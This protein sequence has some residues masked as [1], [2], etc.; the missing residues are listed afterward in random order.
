VTSGL[1][2]QTRPGSGT[3]DVIVIGAGH[4]GLAI[5]HFLTARSIEHVVLE[6]GE[7]ANSWRRERWDSLRLLTPNWQSRLPGFRYSGDDPDG[8]MTVKEVVDF[9]AK[10]AL[11]AD[12]PVETGTTVTAVTSLDEGFSVSTDRGDWRCRAVVVA[13]GACNLPVIP[14][15]SEALP[16]DIVQLTP[17]H[18][19]NPQQI[20]PGGV[21]VV[22]AS[23]TGLQLA[24][25]MQRAGHEVVLAVGEHVRMP[26]SYRGRDIQWWMH[27]AG[28]LDQRYDE[29]DDIGRA[30]RV[31]SPQLIGSREQTFMDLNLIATRGARIAGRLAGIRGGK[32]LFSGSL[33][34]VCALA[35]LKM[36]RLLAA[37]DQWAA[38]SGYGGEVGPAETFPATRVPPT[39]C[40]SLDLKGGAIRTVL[41]A[42][43]YRPDYS[44]L[45]PKALDRKA[46]IRHDGGV[47]AVPGLY[48]IGLP[49]LRRRKSTFIHGAGDDAAD[50]VDHLAGWLATRSQ[51]SRIRVAV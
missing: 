41:W 6:R 27:A 17:L 45:D 20:P 47:G 48:A 36:N 35:D 28:I 21:L 46:R 40:L 37:I 39:P 43:G 3:V 7:I 25:E 9:I 30:R 44:W 42:T 18:Y 11:A 26:R 1:R 12:A 49:F 15:V 10:Y 13:S 31:P 38:E 33:A 22:G 2:A 8:F 29:A 32:A 16:K 14:A 23:A 19:R 4:S 50:I 34:N 51:P 5:S 24:D